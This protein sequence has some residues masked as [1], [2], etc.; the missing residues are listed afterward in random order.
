MLWELACDKCHSK[1]YRGNFDKYWF[2]K[3]IQAQPQQTLTN[4]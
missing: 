1:G 4:P 2:K 3:I